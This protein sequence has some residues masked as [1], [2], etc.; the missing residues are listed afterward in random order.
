M[1]KED[2]QQYVLDLPLH[3]QA[4]F[5]LVETTARLVEVSEKYWQSQGLHGARIRI[6]VEIMKEGGTI[7]PSTLAQKIGVTKSNISLL[8]IPLE[9]EGLLR[10]HPHPSD[11]RKWVLSITSEGENL[12]R[13]YLPGNR[14]VIMEKMQVLN[15][16]ELNQLLVLLHKLRSF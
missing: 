7:L 1:Q 3:N 11:G 2:L 13:Q 10:R 5:A 16:Q 4:F 12:L 15:E 8:L 6:L 14:Q 9:D